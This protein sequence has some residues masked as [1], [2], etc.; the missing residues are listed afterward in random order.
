MRFLIPIEALARHGFDDRPQKAVIEVTISKINTRCLPGRGKMGAVFPIGTTWRKEGLDTDRRR[1]AVNPAVAQARRMR[2]QHTK[3]NGHVRVRRMAQ[4]KAQVLAD[5]VV[6]GQLPRFGEL[7]EGK[8]REHLGDRCHAETAVHRHR[9]GP[10]PVHAADAGGKTVDLTPIGIG[11]DGQA[12]HTGPGIANKGG[13]I[14]IPVSSIHNSS[15]RV[16]KRRCL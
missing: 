12:G 16:W 13:K 6:Q 15:F 2:S 5:I 9:P 4:A 7:H 3:R 11:Q 10:L 14:S 8:D 1:N